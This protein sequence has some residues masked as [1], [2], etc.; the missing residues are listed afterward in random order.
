MPWSEVL[1]ARSATTT[2]SPETTTDG[3][4]LASTQVIAVPVQKVGA[5]AA[6]YLATRALSTTGK[7]EARTRSAAV[8]V[9]HGIGGQ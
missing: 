5:N 7:R 3:C 4:P 2:P 6:T 1:S 9:A 8:R